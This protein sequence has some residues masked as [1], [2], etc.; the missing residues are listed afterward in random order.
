MP[1]F[2]FLMLLIFIQSADVFEMSDY[3]GLLGCFCSANAMVNK[4]S[5]RLH[6]HIY[7]HGKPDRYI[8]LLPLDDCK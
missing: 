7:S 5:S 4:N 1:S 2:V 6:P 3:G 8:P